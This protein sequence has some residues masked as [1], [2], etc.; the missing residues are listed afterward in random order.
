MFGNLFGRFSKDLGMDLG[1]ANVRVYVKGRGVIVN[2]PS[3]VAINLKT[4]QIL[5]LGV[6]AQNMLGKTPPFILTSQPLS[7]GI[8][9]DFEVAQKMIRY[10]IEKAHE[11]SFN[12]VPRPRVVIGV[13][14]EI[15]E[16]ERK[17]VEDAVLYAGARI[18]H[19]VE[20]PM[21]AAIGARINIEEPVG[22]MLVS[23]GAGTTEIS[24]ISLSGIVTWK[25]LK[26]AGD[27]MNKSVVNY[28]RDNFNLILGE[29]VA[30]NIKIATG[31]AYKLKE[32]IQYQ[33]RGR[34][35][36]SG[37]PRE[38][39]INDSEIRE[40]LSKNIRTIIESIKSVLE[41]T[42]PE[43]V[44]DIY[45]RGVLL[46]GGSSL[47]RGLDKTISEAI[48]I[49]VNVATDPL[50]CTVRGAGVLLENPSLLKTVTLPSTNETERG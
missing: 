39:I 11:H 7:H 8:I 50:T 19:L 9:S 45:E 42:P 28:A 30:E 3:V 1:T 32:P 23:I 35:L 22:N 27:E 13:P 6:E 21:L 4:D 24:V 17:A 38:I 36:I 49:P 34:D 37:L 10:F 31:S 33:M 41:I 16:V 48:E 2:E 20:S 25:S 29:R 15:T 44:A 12:I 46:T 5:A 14:L 18:V 26:V 47:L 40:A 43:L